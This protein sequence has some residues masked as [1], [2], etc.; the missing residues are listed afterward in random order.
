[1]LIERPTDNINGSFGTAEK[2][3]SISFNKPKKE[4]KRLSLHYNGE[5]SYLSV[6][7]TTIYKFKADNKNVDFRTQFCLGNI[8]EKFD[9]NESKEVSFKG[10]VYDFSVDYSAF[11]K[12]DILNIHKYLMVKDNIK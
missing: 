6:N 11:D 12:S 10:Y 2:K 9:I 8:S 7:G 5:N 4:K 1:M 3:F